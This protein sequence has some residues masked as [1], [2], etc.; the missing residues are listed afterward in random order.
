MRIDYHSA[1]SGFKE[2]KAHKTEMYE[3]DDIIAFVHDIESKE[4]PEVFFQVDFIYSDLPWENGYETF[5][6]RAGRENNTW[7][8]L[9]MR[10]VEL[11]RK[12][13][14]PFYF[15]GGKGFAKYFPDN[16]CE[17]YHWGIHNYNT[18]I[19]TNNP[20]NKKIKDV[21]S[22]IEELYAIYDV[23]LDFCCGYGSLG[24][25][26]KLTGKKAILTD[27]N[28]YCIGYIEITSPQL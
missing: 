17:E 11:T 19:Y 9:V 26:A 8:E 5:N 14:K 15:T 27:I 16:S 4:I 3:D 12:L 28:P 10:A 7:S 1:L 24:K 13:D 6:K 18:R 2:Y 21:E 22:Y 23:G 25:F 20:I